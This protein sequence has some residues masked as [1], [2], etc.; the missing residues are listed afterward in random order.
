VDPFE[1]LSLCAEVAVA[2]AGFSGVVLAFGDRA[3]IAPDGPDR[4]LFMSLFRGSLTPLG[5]IALAFT[6]NAFGLG[7]HAVWQLCSSAHAIIIV[8]F[9]A[10]AWPTVPFS[11]GGGTIFRIGG[12]LILA[13]SLANVVAIQAFWPVLAVIFWGLGASLWAFVSLLGGSRAA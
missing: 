6:S 1:V 12:I 11:S 4:V 10:I 13:L 3:R 7:S 8:A 9:F 2:I 5:I